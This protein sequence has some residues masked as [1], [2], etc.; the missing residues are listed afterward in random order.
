MTKPFVLIIEDE[1]YLADIY[2][3][4]LQAVEFETDVASDGD[5][6]LSKLA[7]VIPDLVLLDL[8]LPRVAGRDILKYIRSDE[9][10]KDLKVILTTADALVAEV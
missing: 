7:E 2:A 5:M 6:A 3:L 1:A 10:L 8:H 4:A 9:R